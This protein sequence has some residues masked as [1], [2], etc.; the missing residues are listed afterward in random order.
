MKQAPSSVFMVRPQHFGYNPE[1]AASNAFQ[2]KILL[3]DHHKITQNALI[4]FDAFADQLKRHLIDVHVFDS[5]K[6][7]KAPDAVFPN[8]WISFH[9]DGKIVLY[10]MLTK[11]RRIERRQEIIEALSGKFIVKEV[12]DISGSESEGKILEGTGSI[13][14]DHKNRIAYANASARTDRNLFYDVCQQLGYEGVFFK[15]VDERGLDIYHTNVMMTIGDGFAVICKAS[16]DQDDVAKVINSLQAGGLEVID[17]S[18]RQLNHFAGNMIQLENT[19]HE[20][21]LVMSNSAFSVLEKG[22]I[23]RLSKYVNFVHPEINTIETVGGGSARC[24]IAGIH[25][26]ER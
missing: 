9:E 7:H 8:N 2:K 14:F 23:D 10:P 15:A 22:Q 19:N 20:N 24:M 11:N 1:T 6:N 3:C 25:L 18:Y 5:P 4:E 13:V 12:I 16:I 26:Q 21:F 17:I